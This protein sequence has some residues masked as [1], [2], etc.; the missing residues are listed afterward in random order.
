[1]PGG[2]T[3]RAVPHVVRES[4]LSRF[5]TAHNEPQSSRNETN[6][7]TNDL[8]RTAGHARQM[9]E[10]HGSVTAS[11]QRESHVSGRYPD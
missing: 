10:N 4:A 6:L 3:R 7:G 9:H 5:A 11:P 1:M 8:E 2:K